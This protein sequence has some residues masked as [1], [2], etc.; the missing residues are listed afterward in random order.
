MVHVG[1]VQESPHVCYGFGGV[2]VEGLK[3]S[4]GEKLKLVTVSG[5][6]G[7]ATP[8]VK[9]STSIALETQGLKGSRENLS[10]GIM[11]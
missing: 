5:Q 3:E 1:S 10:V 6:N 8:L 9:T 4:R 11:W 7:L 2:R